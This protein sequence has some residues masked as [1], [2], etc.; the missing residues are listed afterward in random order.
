[1]SDAPQVGFAPFSKAPRGVLILLCE[2]GLKLGS[3]ARK[4][5]APSG[6]LLRRADE[7]CAQTAVHLT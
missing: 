4:A 3:A 7:S 6:D 1:M 2:E 5:L